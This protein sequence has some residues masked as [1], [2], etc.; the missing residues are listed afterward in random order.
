MRWGSEERFMPKSPD[1]QERVAAFT[2]AYNLDAPLGA[3]LL[4]LSA[5]VGEIAS[6]YLKNT[7]YGKDGFQ[8]SEEW[9]AE[10]GDAF[11]S[12]IAVANHTGVN[13]DQALTSALEKYIDRIDSKGD[14]GSR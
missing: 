3:Q 6:E 12:L 8:R 13:L 5:E 11:Y 7:S 4:D 14:P 9:R 2:T 10:L 1:Y